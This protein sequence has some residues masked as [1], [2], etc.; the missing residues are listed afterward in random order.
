MM[1]PDLE[2][3]GSCLM[4]VVGGAEAAAGEVKRLGYFGEGRSMGGLEQLQD[5]P[6]CAE[7]RQVRERDEDEL[8]GKEKVQCCTTRSQIKGKCSSQGTTTGH[9][10]SGVD[11]VSCNLLDATPPVSRRAPRFQ[12]GPGT[13]TGQMTQLQAALP[14]LNR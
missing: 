10:R 13:F 5:N 14:I 2:V 11:A 12:A 3:C 4:V 6:R 1:R 8:D 7:T 9:G